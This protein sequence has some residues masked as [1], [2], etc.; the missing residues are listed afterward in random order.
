MNN[1]DKM[2]NNGRLGKHADK[3]F[4]PSEPLSGTLKI[5]EPVNAKTI[6]QIRDAYAKFRG[7]CSAMPVYPGDWDNQESKLAIARSID[8]E[9][10]T[11]NNCKYYKDH[12]IEELLADNKLLRD[13][14]ESSM[15]HVPF[16]S[17]EHHDC[18]KA[19]EQT[20]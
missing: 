12:R 15:V 16:N 10:F 17:V 14:L 1:K 11:I 19:L 5:S 18:V 2:I 3:C 8:A 6:E 4:N 7:P 9:N 13:V 20:K